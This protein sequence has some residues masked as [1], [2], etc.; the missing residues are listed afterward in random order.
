MK[1]KQIGTSNLFVSP[2]GLGCM[3]LQPNSRESEYILDKAVDLGVNYFDTADLYDFGKNEELLG[4][5]LATKR[6]DVMIATKVGNEWNNSKTSWSWNPTKSYIKDAVKNSLQRLQTDYIDLCQLHGGTID[7]PIDEAIE[8]FEELTKEG[9]IRYYGLSSIR[10]NVIKEYVKKSNIVSVMMQYSLLD[11]RPE[12][13]ILPLL[14]KHKI[15]VITRGPMAK[16]LLTENFQ[17][18]LAETDYLSYSNR[19]LQQ[20]LPK[21]KQWSHDYGYHFHELA[22]LYCL[23]SKAVSAVVPGASSLNQLQENL[24]ALDKPLLS[25]QQLSELQS[26]IKVSNY[27]EHL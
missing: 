6:T 4:R 25:E 15:S 22:L 18:K 26:L 1:K 11:R 27:T 10:P 24:A 2:V 13:E 23:A 17:D 16:G 3:S 12:P 7:D 14:N 19:E 8:A 21:L 5:V 20:T 9:L